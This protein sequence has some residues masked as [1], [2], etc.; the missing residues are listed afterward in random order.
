MRNDASHSDILLSTSDATWQAYNAYGG[1]S[2][3]ACTVACP[4]GN[5]RLQGGVRGVVQPAFGGPLASDS[6]QSYLYY[7]E[8]QMIRFLEKNGYDVSYT[9]SSDVDPTARSC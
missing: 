9:S 4:P 7:A 8:Y 6:G 2:L 3:Y 1:N 5:P